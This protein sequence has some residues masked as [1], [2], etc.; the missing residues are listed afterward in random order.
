MIFPLFDEGFKNV[1][2]SVS[3]AIR[4]GLPRKSGDFLAMTGFKVLLI[5]YLFLPLTNSKIPSK[6]PSETFC[7]KSGEL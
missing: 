5:N 7:A 1:I 6:I 3:E 4:N 2:A